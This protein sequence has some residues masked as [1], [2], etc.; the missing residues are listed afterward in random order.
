A[1]SRQHAPP[2]SKSL[3]RFQ[4]PAELKGAGFLQVQNSGQDD[5]RFLFLPE[6]KRA[7]RISGNLRSSS[8]MGTDF[9]YAD[10]DRRDLREGTP[11]LL[12]EAPLG[13][14]ACYVL[15]VT[16]KRADTK[17]SKTE[18]WVRKDNFIPAKMLMFDK[19][20]TLLKT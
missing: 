20:G 17:Y 10:L 1:R 3:V 6:L 12:E 15:S 13:G 11:T 8:F 19:S 7:R 2:L 9:S 18:L 14:V 16:P 5:D 4:A